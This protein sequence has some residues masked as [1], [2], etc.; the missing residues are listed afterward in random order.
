MQK[1]LSTLVI[2]SQV[3]R[4]RIGARA[5]VFA[6]ERLGHPAWFLPTITLPWHPGHGKGQRIV[7]P[8]DEFAAIIDDL[9]GNDQLGSLAGVITG[10]LGNAEQAAPIAKLIKA[11]KSLNPDLLY[12]CDPVIGDEGGLY[13]PEETAAAIRDQLLPLADL[14]TPNRFEFDWL[15]A[16][17]H[18]INEDIVETAKTLSHRYVAVTSAFAMMKQS[19]GTLLYD[20]GANDALL[21]E[22]RS[23]ENAPNGP[24]DLFAGLLMAR[25]LSGQTPQKALQTATAGVFDVLAQTVKRGADELVLVEEQSRIDHPMAMVNMRRVGGPVVRRKGTVAKPT[26]LT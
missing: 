8:S 18:A 3:V 5:S 14:I 17:T 23:F 19:Q 1:T 26:S 7:A 15:T 12:C 6:L 21:A 22:H 20:S 24:G 25:L 4:G 10:Y 16:K 13:V 11:A 2:T 9:I